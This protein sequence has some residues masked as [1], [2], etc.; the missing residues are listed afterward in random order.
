M[1]ARLGAL[2]S[3]AIG[4]L[5]NVS[6]MFTSAII[7]KNEITHIQLLGFFLTSYGVYLNS[8][9]GGEFKDDDEDELYFR[10]FFFHLIFF[11]NSNFFR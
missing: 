3:M 4:N 10:L 7:F 2:S 1:V 6:I 11:I 9:Y 5:K 8:K